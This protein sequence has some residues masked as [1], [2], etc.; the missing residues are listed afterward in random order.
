MLLH[1]ERQTF[2]SQIQIECALGRLDRSKVTHQLRCCLGDISAG[3]AEALH[4]DHAVIAVVG[5]A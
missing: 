3:Q 4:V 2:Q 5:G 1:A